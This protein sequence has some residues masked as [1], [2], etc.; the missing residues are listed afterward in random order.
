MFAWWRL[1]CRCEKMGVRMECWLYACERDNM[2]I[3]LYINACTHGRF[4]F[5][6]SLWGEIWELV[7]WRWKEWGCPHDVDYCSLF[8]RGLN[9]LLSSGLPV[10][11]CVYKSLGQC[12]FNVCMRAP[13]YSTIITLMQPGDASLWPIKTATH[14]STHTTYSVQCAKGDK[15][16]RQIL[17]FPFLYF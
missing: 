17:F 15:Q 16:A 4:R 12:I 6:F 10:H 13:L 9:Q 8:K 7:V 11:S 2:V 1:F 14:P 5:V 3:C